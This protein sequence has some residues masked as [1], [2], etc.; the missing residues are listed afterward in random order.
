MFEGAE[1]GGPVDVADVCGVRFEI[2]GMRKRLRDALVVRV[3][4]AG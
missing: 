4:H 2:G 1:L 3:A